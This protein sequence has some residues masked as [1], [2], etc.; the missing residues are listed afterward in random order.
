MS[1]INHA[2]AMAQEEPNGIYLFDLTDSKRKPL[3][4]GKQWIISFPEPK[5]L[6]LIPA[7]QISRTVFLSIE[8][9]QCP[10]AWAADCRNLFSVQLATQSFNLGKGQ[11]Q[12]ITLTSSQT[13]FQ[14]FLNTLAI[15]DCKEKQTNP[16][17]LYP[18]SFSVVLSD[19]QENEIDRV[20]ELIYVQF[21][22]VH[23]VP[24]VT[25]G[26]DKPEIV[27]SSSLAEAPHTIGTL[28]IADES[29]FD[30]FPFICCDVVVKAYDDG[31]KMAE[32]CLFLNNNPERNNHP[33]RLDN[34][35][36]SRKEAINW[37]IMADFSKIGN[38]HQKDTKNIKITVSVQ[39]HHRGDESN[40]SQ[41]P[42]KC[43]EFVL[44]RDPQKAE[45]VIQ[46]QDG[47][48]E[49]WHE[50]ENGGSIKL[51][52]FSFLPGGHL[53]S[54]NELLFSNLA[55]NGLPGA[56][57]YIRKF[58][59][60]VKLSPQCTQVMYNEINNGENTI[61]DLKGDDLNRLSDELCLKSNGDSLALQFGFRGDE[62]KYAF[63]QLKNGKKVYAFEVIYRISFEYY[64]SD[65]G[66]V[67]LSDDKGVHLSKGPDANFRE[68]VAVFTLPIYQQPYQ[69]WLG[70]DFG[71]SAIVC[72]YG[73]RLLDLHRIK[74]HLF[75]GYEGDE[76]EKGTPFLSSN[77]VFRE[78]VRL[79]QPISQLLTEHEADSYPDYKE[80]AVCLSPP[81]SV[82][83]QNIRSILPYLKLMAGYQRLPHVERYQHIVYLHY[84]KEK[85][86][87]KERVFEIREGQKV[88]SSL[89]H[90]NKIFEEVYKELFVYYIKEAIR[91]EQAQN[92]NQIVLTVPNTYTPL[93][94]KKL[95]AC[96]ET[97]FAQLYIRN[98]KFVSESDAVACF[99]QNNW[100]HINEMIERDVADSPLRNN[101]NIL[102]YDMGAGTLDVTLLTKTEEDGK[103]E[104]RVLRKIGI[105]KAGNYLDYILAKLLAKHIP[106]FEAYVQ[107][108]LDMDALVEARK[109]KEFVKNKLKPVLGI[110]ETITI[111]RN[112]VATLQKDVVL[113]VNKLLEDADFQRY[114][115]DCTEGFFGNFFTPL[116]G[117]TPIR[118]DTVL[119]SGRSSKLKFIQ[120]GLQKAVSKYASN[121]SWKLVDMSALTREGQYDKSKTVVV[122]GALA[123][124]GNYG[125]PDSPI[126]FI[127]SNIV[128]NYGIKY[129]GDD[130]RVRYKELLTPFHQPVA[131]HEKNGLIINEYQTSLIHLDLSTEIQLI[132]TFS[133]DTERDLKKG[134]LEYITEMC[135]Y[136]IPNPRHVG[137]RLIVDQDNIMTLRINGAPREGI[138]PSMIDLES[139][140][141]Q[142]SLWPTAKFIENYE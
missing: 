96:I 33:N 48:T 129:R 142:I 26:L 30:Y 75:D 91:G 134:N 67:P 99:Y 127:S 65:D 113:S 35:F 105:A 116:C 133:A 4:I 72:Q 2:S 119:V 62:I 77:L 112:T 135:S 140:S 81:S 58:E 120:E 114:I 137:V 44:R 13:Y 73:Q 125:S 18:L 34:L 88:Y 68:F 70:I 49:I 115:F 63:Y 78:R 86:L 126:K 123:Y 109:L 102:V 23:T 103:K 110:E 19:V 131:T 38:P 94:L 28:R 54:S 90:V 92:I 42:L 61:F 7:R 24:R 82:E 3:N 6:F 87:V 5:E 15:T 130:G 22:E 59:W 122:E 51:S 106:Q 37:D 69:D 56:G 124:A 111:P 98:I 9:I 79:K 10:E 41:L 80:L 29:L 89:S 57:V 27:Y 46:V 14:L 141:N 66:C 100:A 11:K 83:D 93:H 139:E 55:K 47:Q 20:E 8:H 138:V 121:D 104:I 85:E 40:K 95:Q 107:I 39:Y 12:E 97:S 1:A 64:L 118:I 16:S 21:N 132:Q 25:I 117:D 108:D 53:V 136:T 32:E 71:T 60:S 31:E 84:N 36:L 45:L 74:N 101:E 76:Y 128:A 52:T 43:A 50:L 17:T